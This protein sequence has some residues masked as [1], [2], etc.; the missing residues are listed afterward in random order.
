MKIA[1]R[2]M[3]EREPATRPQRVPR[4]ANIR[5]DLSCAQRAATPTPHKGWE[6]ERC[7]RDDP[8]PHLLIGSGVLRKRSRGFPRLVN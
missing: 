2:S 8:H 3:R 6:A 1:T 5:D 4:I 7:G